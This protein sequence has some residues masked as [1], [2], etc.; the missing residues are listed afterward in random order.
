MKESQD[1]GQHSRG[2]KALGTLRLSCLN[3]AELS[4]ENNRHHQSQLMQ[5]RTQDTWCAGLLYGKFTSG[6]LGNLNH[7]AE[8]EE[9]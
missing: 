9:I 4:L 5:K 3:G 6:P 2:S 1:E 8:F 7:V